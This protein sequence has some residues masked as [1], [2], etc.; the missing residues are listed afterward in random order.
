[1]YIINSQAVSSNDFHYFLSVIWL[2]L[3]YI[4][5]HELVVSESKLI[6]LNSII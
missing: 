2:H 5:N 3:M 6:L 1:M 4:N